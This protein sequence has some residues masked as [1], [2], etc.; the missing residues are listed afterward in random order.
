MHGF[1]EHCG[2]YDAFS[3]HLAA[4]GHAVCRFDARGHGQSGGRRGHVRDFDEYVSDFAEFARSAAK[5]CPS[6]PLAVLGHS[7]GGLIALRAV[8]QGLVAPA[9]LVL[10]S[11]LLRLRKKPVPD[12]VARFLSWAAPALPLPNGIRRQ[13]LT[14][15]PELL[16][17]HAADPLVHRIATP[18]WY[19]TMTRAS[20]R[21]F[22]D[23]SR[24][25]LPLLVVCG[26]L[27]PL[28]D[29]AGAVELHALAASRT[30][31]LTLRR[32]EFHEV[33]NETRRVELY[34]Q[35][36]VWLEGALSAPA[37]AAAS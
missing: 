9:A 14:H 10:T 12:I 20:E 8:Q 21:A 23:A 37:A 33:L 4:R 30:K 17:A 19:W 24:L 29:P 31:Q 34:D 11:P 35:I 2:R 22:A 36:A 5:R 3:A 25:T 1:A 16:A 15:D 6:V 13:D 28:V 26:E 27:D 32:G 18:R 7:N